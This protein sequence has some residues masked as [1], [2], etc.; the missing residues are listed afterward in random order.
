MK[1]Q[2]RLSHSKEYEYYFVNT[3]FEEYGEI[4]EALFLKG[5]G[6]L[7]GNAYVKE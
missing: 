4:V 7:Y 2:T 5:P 6:E 1:A 3:Q